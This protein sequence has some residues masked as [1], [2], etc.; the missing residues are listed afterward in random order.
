MNG[1]KE[2][3]RI[4]IHADDY[5]VSLHASRDLITCLQEGKLDSISI[6]PTMSCY[7]S[8]MKLLLE[9]WD[10]FKKKPLISVHLNFM[11]GHSVAKKEQVPMLVDENGYFKLS[12]GDLLK[13]NYT[14]GKRKEL[15]KQLEIEIQAQI[16]KVTKSIHSLQKEIRLDS[17]QHTHMIPVVMDGMMDAIKNRSYPVSFI[18]V[19]REP[20]LPFLKK[21]SFYKSYDVLNMVKN[22]ILNFFSNQV[23]R[24]LKI[25]QIE[26]NL[27]WGLV[28][29]GHMDLER[30]RGLYASMY[31]SAKRKNRELEILFHPGTVLKEEITKEYGKEGF[32]AFHLSKGRQIERKAVDEMDWEKVL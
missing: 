22:L 27:L 5:G 10:S 21:V 1:C 31:Q 25:L 9:N 15:R 16:D 6:I 24:K 12:W 7:D 14:F 11:E 2:K 23:E 4:D 3:K 17:H 18:R 29:S 8:C 30:C 32:V 26:P 28:M 13:L 20:L 19:A